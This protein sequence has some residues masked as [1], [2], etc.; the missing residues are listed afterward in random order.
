MRKLSCPPHG[1]LTGGPQGYDT[2][3]RW[4]FEQGDAIVAGRHAVSLLGGGDRYEAWLAWD[5]RL[6]S[7]VVAKLLRCG[8]P[9]MPAHVG[10]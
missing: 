4:T 9:V 2:M 8:R 1:R 3:D 6:R 5:E 10:A 7:L